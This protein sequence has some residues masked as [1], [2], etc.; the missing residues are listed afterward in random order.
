[1]NLNNQSRSPH[2]FPGNNLIALYTGLSILLK[3]R[4]ELGLEAMLV[5]ME[6]YSQLIGK[7]NPEIQ[8]A[9]LKALAASDMKKIYQEAMQ[10]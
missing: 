4:R 3:M 8:R 1:M 2:H 7:A 5:Y 6:K 10:P 9:V